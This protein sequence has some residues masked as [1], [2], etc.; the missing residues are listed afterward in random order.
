[1]AFEMN[2][3]TLDGRVVRGGMAFDSVSHAKN[4]CYLTPNGSMIKQKDWARFRQLAADDLPA[5]VRVPRVPTA[6]DEVDRRV[7]MLRHT[8]RGYGL[9][10]DSIDEACEICR[11]ELAGEPVEDE[12]PTSGPG[13]ARNLSNS[14]SREPGE[15]VFKS[16]G[17]FEARPP[18]GTTSSSEKG[19][20]PLAESEYRSSPASD[21]MRVR[22][23]VPGNSQFDGQHDRRSK[24][25]RRLAADSASDAAGEHL[26]TMFPGISRI[27]IG[28]WPKRR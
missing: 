4:G 28:E 15:K 21:A 18:L 5:S 1:M 2:Y 10:D 11:R 12:L 24:R 7:G 8:L 20:S 13:G 25:E 22:I 23:G 16:H 3:R 27:G 26:E 17:R 6:S 9:D 19:R 14:Q